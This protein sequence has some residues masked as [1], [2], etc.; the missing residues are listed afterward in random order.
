ML[1]ILMSP[2]QLST[3]YDSM[4]LRFHY[5]CCAGYGAQFH[6]HSSCTQTQVFKQSLMG[7]H[8]REISTEKVCL[9][10]GLEGEGRAAAHTETMV[11]TP[12]LG[13][14]LASPFPTN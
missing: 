3:L 11:M 14:A 9:L 7:A 2:F 10:A 12:R 8:H 1:M 13:W 5:L 6:L 4:K